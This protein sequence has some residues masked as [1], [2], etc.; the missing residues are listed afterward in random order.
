MH[1]AFW[2]PIYLSLTISLT[3][4]IVVGVFG[5]I[6][7]FIGGR[8]SFKGKLMLETVALLPIVLPPSVVGF[9]LIKLFG[10]TSFFG[11]FIEW[12]FG[13]SILFTWWAATIAASVVAFPLMYQMAKTGFVQIDKEIE[14]AAAVDGASKAMVFM[15]I[16][17]PLA[18]PAIL[19]GLLLS[20]AR[21]FGEFGATLM[22]AGN[23]PGK[24][25]TIPTAIYVAMEAGD[26]FIAWLY[27]VM[28]VVVS[29]LILLLSTMFQRKML[30]L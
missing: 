22:F 25:Q 4:A 12:L 15:Y 5:T 6:T 7:G 26:M 10:H 2:Q 8:K 28:C 1:L 11:R 9:L 18:K 16:T 24:T 27:V 20:F 3:A 19:T 21:A 29:V 13:E 23:I 14:G 30:K 17:L